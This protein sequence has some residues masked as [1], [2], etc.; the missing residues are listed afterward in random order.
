MSV[1]YGSVNMVFAY[2]LK[3]NFASMGALSM[4]LLIEVS[5]V[6]VGFRVAQIRHGRGGQ[7]HA[8][9]AFGSDDWHRWVSADPTTGSVS[10]MPVGSSWSPTITQTDEIS[11]LENEQQVMRWVLSFRVHDCIVLPG[12]VSVEVFQGRVAF[13][14]LIPCSRLH[15]LYV[16][17]WTVTEKL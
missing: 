3:F 9:W 16:P 7:W 2:G 14:L 12:N 4:Q 5:P 6:V 8:V 1:L 13:R 17:R 11:Q 15:Y 10:T